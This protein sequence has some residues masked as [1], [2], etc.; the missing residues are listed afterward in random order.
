ML[1]IRLVFAVV[2]GSPIPGEHTLV[3]LPEVPLP[4]WAQGIRLGGEVTAG[5][6]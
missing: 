3:T 6:W 4:A 2:F 5:C 1:L